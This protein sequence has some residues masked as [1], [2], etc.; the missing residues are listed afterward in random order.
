MLKQSSYSVV[1]NVSKQI[2]SCS[3]DGNCCLVTQLCLLLL[4]PHGL[5]PTR[6][7]CPW[8][9]PGRNAGVVAISFP[10]EPSQ[11]KEW[12]QVS[13]IGRWILYHCATRK[14]LLSWDW[15]SLPPEPTFRIISSSLKC[16]NLFPLGT[17]FKQVF[18]GTCLR[19]FIILL[20]IM[21]NRP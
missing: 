5:Y 7:L 17:E 3:A 2:L 11:P 19:M 6:L 9:F 16:T 1:K 12:T 4:R 15:Y 10:R 8:Q 13:C 18:T 20:F 21:A 14:A